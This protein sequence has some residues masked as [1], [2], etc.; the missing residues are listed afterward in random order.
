MTVVAVGMLL[1][2]TGCGSTKGGT[3]TPSTGAGGTS[4]ATAA[5]WDPCT[6]VSDQVLQKVGVVPSTKKSG[7]AGVEEPGWKVCAWNSAPSL[8]DYTV[9][10]YSTIHNVDE[11]KKKKENVDFVGIKVQGRDGFRFH[12]TNDKDNEDC[13][14]VFPAAQ[15]A[16]Q[17]SVFKAS[18]NKP[19][20][21]CDQAMVAAD[22]LVPLFPR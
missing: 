4:A 8:W 6:Q 21:A 22:T 2:V 14:L 18:P 9:T 10:V 12:T 11:Y 1:V 5:L 15:G 3:A 7:V 20:V 13:D 16:L 17:I 19:V